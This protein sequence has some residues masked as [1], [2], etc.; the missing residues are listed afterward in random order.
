[1][2]ADTPEIW[3]SGF[4]IRE[5]GGGVGGKGRGRGSIRTR[6]HPGGVSQSAVSFWSVSQRPQGWELQPVKLQVD[7]SLGCHP[8]SS[9][10]NGLYGLGWPL[11]LPLLL[12]RPVIQGVR[13]L[14]LSPE[15]CHGDHLKFINK[16]PDSFSRS[17]VSLGSTAWVRLCRLGPGWTTI[18]P[19]LGK[20]RWGRIHQKAKPRLK[21]SIRGWSLW[22]LEA[23]P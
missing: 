22:E 16:P 5:R 9:H 14:P 10:I 3:N 19:G 21:A 1:M 23:G 12:E 7:L 6:G 17:D 18:L 15:S 20:G 11:S 2:A 4:L 13:H 8:S